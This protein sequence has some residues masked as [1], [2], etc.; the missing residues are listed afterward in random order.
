MK[1]AEEYKYVIICD[2]T[3]FG[4][5]IDH[6]SLFNALETTDNKELIT[7]LANLISIISNLRQSSLPVGATASK[8]LAEYV[9]NRIDHILHK[10][11]VPFCRFVD[12]FHLYANTKKEAYSILYNLSTELIH[13]EKLSLHKNKSRILTSDEFKHYIHHVICG[14]KPDISLNDGLELLSLNLQDKDVRANL[15]QVNVYNLLARELNKGEIYDYFSKRLL[16]TF[17]YLEQESL[18][19]IIQ[20]T[21]DRFDKL[22]PIFTS[23]MDVLHRNFYKLS[24]HIK[25]RLIHQI[26]RL[27]TEEHHITLIELNVAYMLTIIQFQKDINTIEIIRNT[28]EKWKDSKLIKSIIIQIMVK[29][30]MKDDLLI[31]LSQFNGSSEWERKNYIIVSYILNEEG[32]IWRKNNKQHFTHT[33]NTINNWM[34]SK[35]KASSI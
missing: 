25:G 27:F 20:L 34:K 30:N 17:N 21:L 1:Y 10:K 2:I 8:I 16:N 3:D 12:D 23:F 29:W 11:N 4:F 24:D 9:L 26:T 14:K 7:K 35:E 31:L 5:R 6:K 32:S 22:Y 13:H 33:E 19:E 15:N 18:N 28:F